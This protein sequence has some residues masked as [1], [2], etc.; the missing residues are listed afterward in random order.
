MLKKAD[1]LTPSWLKRLDKYLLLN[2]PAIWASRIH[3]VLFFGGVGM[4]LLLAKAWLGPLSLSNIPDPDFH[5]WLAAVPC[6]LLL[7]LLTYQLSLFRLESKFGLRPSGY[8][9]FQ[10]ISLAVSLA[11]LFLIPLVYAQHLNFRI[12][13]ERS[14]S[15]LSQELNQLHMGDVYFPTASY[16]FKDRARQDGTYDFEMHRYRLYGFSTASGLLDIHSTYELRAA[17]SEGQFSD[18]ERLEQIE[19]F[20]RVFN[21]YCHDPIRVH[22]E[23]VLT[24]FQQQQVPVPYLSEKKKEVEKNIGRLIRAKEMSFDFQSSH[25]LHKMMVSYLSV[26]LLVLLFLKTQSQ[27]YFLALIG[28]ALGFSL[29]MV[30]LPP[31]ASL[32]SL[33]DGQLLLPLQLFVNLGLLGVYSYKGRDRFHALRKGVSLILL[34]LFLPFLPYAVLASDRFYDPTWVNGTL[35]LGFVFT[36]LVINSWLFPRLTR[37]M[38]QPTPN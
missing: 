12:G 21:T 7:P 29:T 1:I 13:S 30:L 20:I 37:L 17:H 4:G 28:S 32:L 15:Q 33:K 6:I 27:A 34:T 9:A 3:Y 31:L 23:Q 24:R 11:L 38:A 26:W 2:H 18:R 19:A 14:A 8:P 5:F 22:P 10:Q 36:L 25:F 35:Y 16:V